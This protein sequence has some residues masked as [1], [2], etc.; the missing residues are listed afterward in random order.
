MNN[1]KVKNIL[2][3]QYTPHNSDVKGLNANQYG[4]LVDV[5]RML[6]KIGEVKIRVKLHPGVWKRSYYN[7][8]KDMFNLQCD[9]RDDGPFEKHVDWADVVIGPAQSGAYLEVLAAEKPYYPVNMNPYSKMLELDRVKV[10]GTVS[11][12]ENDLLLGIHANQ[13]DVLEELISY[14]EFPNPAKRLMSVLGRP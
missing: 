13:T 12:L 8:I 5:V 3:L 9:I 7:R 14:N 1:D 10:Y 2:I 11:Q 4:Y 6:K